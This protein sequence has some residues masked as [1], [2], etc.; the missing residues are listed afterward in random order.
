MS[1]FLVAWRQ[2]AFVFDFPAMEA[3]FRNL[4]KTPLC[5]P[6][7]CRYF[8]LRAVGFEAMNGM[9]SDMCL[10]ARDDVPNAVSSGVM[11]SMLRGF[12]PKQWQRAPRRGLRTHARHAQ[13]FDH[14]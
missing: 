14:G 7:P 5:I 8:M 13:R 12:A 3:F 2:K 9:L 11:E 1:E 10:E 4:T 6:Q